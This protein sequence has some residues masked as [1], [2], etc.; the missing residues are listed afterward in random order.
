MGFEDEHDYVEEINADYVKR[1]EEKNKPDVQPGFSI[2]NSSIDLKKAEDDKKREYLSKL[3]NA[4][5]IDQHREELDKLNQSV[6]YLA[7]K[8]SED[9]SVINEILSIVKGNHP[10]V[11]Q[12]NIAHEN[13]MQKI[14]ALS[15]L[16]Q[17]LAEAYKLFKGDSQA[18]QPLISQEIINEKMTKTFFDNLETGE[19]INDFIKN[20]LKKTVT[21]KIVNQALS[22]IGHEAAEHGPI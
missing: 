13:P 3:S 17:P 18:P 6:T 8:M 11:P 7:D 5:G 14:E 20:S 10:Q 16:I 4:L 12:E 22:E 2:G 9:R 1:L 19:S 15:Q 21:R